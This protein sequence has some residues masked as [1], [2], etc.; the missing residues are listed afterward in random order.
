MIGRRNAQLDTNVRLR[1]ELHAGGA[2]VVGERDNPTLLYGLPYVEHAYIWEE[3]LQRT[4]VA[5]LADVRDIGDRRYG[6]FYALP[7]LDAAIMFARAVA[8]QPTKG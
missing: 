1:H 6:C 3:S 2:V 4:V 7:T 8:P 5:L